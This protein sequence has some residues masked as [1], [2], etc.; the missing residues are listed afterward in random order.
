MGSFRDLAAKAE[1]A[2]TA[3]RLT[4]VFKQ[5][6]KAGD[7]I[8]GAYISHAAVGSE[9][10][11]KPYNQYLFETDEGLVKFHMGSAADTEY[12]AQFQKGNVYLVRFQGK[13]AIKGGRTVNKFDVFQVGHVT[14]V[15]GAPVDAGS[16]GQ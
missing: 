4:P 13:E 10:E 15:E 9:G 14:D 6:E 3:A 11:G 16:D 2:K 8:I 12:A 7:E 5:F 1:K